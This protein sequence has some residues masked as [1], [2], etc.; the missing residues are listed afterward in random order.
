MIVSRT[1]ATDSKLHGLAFHAT[2]I[3]TGR[4]LLLAE[5]WALVSQVCSLFIIG[6]IGLNWFVLFESRLHSNN[7]EIRIKITYAGINRDF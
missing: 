7:F 5:L 3:R 1:G 4:F 2:I 6:L